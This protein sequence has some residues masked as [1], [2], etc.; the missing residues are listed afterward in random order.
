MRFGFFSND[1]ARDWQFSSANWDRIRKDKQQHDILMHGTFEEKKEKSLADI[2]AKA[3]GDQTRAAITGS[4]NVAT[5]KEANKPKYAKLEAEAP[6]RKAE[7][8][9]YN[10]QAEKFSSAAELFN[11]QASQQKIQNSFTPK[12]L[13]ALTD[14]PARGAVVLGG[15]NAATTL[16]SR[17]R[18]EA[19]QEAARKAEIAKAKAKKKKE[20]TYELSTSMWG[21]F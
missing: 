17:R 10:A 11:A 15:G 18:E 6:L 12:V 8:N 19:L 20:D 2:L 5:Q 16:A 1:A 9:T 7:T 13:S 21:E 4:Y 14:D 3:T